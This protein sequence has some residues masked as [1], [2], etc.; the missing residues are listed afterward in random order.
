MTVFVSFPLQTFEE[1]SGLLYYLRVI[2]WF[3][4]MVVITAAHLFLTMILCMTV[5]GITL[6][7][8]HYMLIRFAAFPMIDT[9]KTRDA[10]LFCD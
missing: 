8:T 1:N 7:R 10:C 9:A 4:F 6:A 3:P 5:S 2:L